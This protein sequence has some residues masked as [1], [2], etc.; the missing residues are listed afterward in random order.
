MATNDLN[1]V[2]ISKDSYSRYDQADWNGLKNY[3]ASGVT[4]IV[5]ATGEKFKGPDEVIRFMQTYKEAVPDET[6]RIQKQ[7]SC[8]DLVVTE[9][10]VHGTHTGVW[11]S[12]MGDIPPTGKTVD[13]PCLE[14]TQWKN[15]KI[16]DIHQY[17]D[18]ATVMNQLGINMATAQH[19]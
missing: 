15:G 7:T 17:Y 16:T 5:E 1:L 8:E 9:M 19:A 2:Q 11:R 6:L 12:P 18:R 13:V 14:V 3:L 4:L 10:I